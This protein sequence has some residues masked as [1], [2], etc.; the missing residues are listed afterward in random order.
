MFT[1]AA[2]HLVKQ[3]IWDCKHFT[4]DFFLHEI[5]DHCFIYKV[6]YEVWSLDRNG[7]ES[8]L[9]IQDEKEEGTQHLQY[10]P[11]IIFT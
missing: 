2:Y 3:T 8:W 4:K 6:L 9:K 1:R 10:T 7:V 5:N 11:K